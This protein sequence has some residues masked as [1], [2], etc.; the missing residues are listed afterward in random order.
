MNHPNLLPIEGVAPQ[1][2]KLSMVYRW[3]VN[4]NVPQYLGRY[5]ETN[6]LGLV[7]LI[8]SQPGSAFIGLQIIGVA[9]GLGY[10]HDNGVVHGDLEGVSGDGA[11]LLISN[12]SSRQQKVL[13]DAEGNPRLYG[14]RYCSF[15]DGPRSSTY[16]RHYRKDRY[17]APEDPRNGG[18]GTNKS[19]VYSLS[20]FVVEVCLSLEGE[21]PTP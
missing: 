9:R 3:M 4:G 7:C 5:P 17:R 19:D 20:M 2:S 10:L 8:H 18:R 14:F 1:I 6:R 21:L 13:I 15:N 12:G 11:I 16:L